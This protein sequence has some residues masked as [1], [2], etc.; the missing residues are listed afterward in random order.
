MNGADERAR[1]G[2]LALGTSFLVLLTKTL[3]FVLTGSAAIY[4]DAM[5][6]IVNVAAAGALVWGLRVAARPAD[7][8]HPY[9]HGKVEFFTAGL[10][11]ALIIV[12][13]ALI[14][15]QAIRNLV[16]GEFPQEL[17]AGVSLL[18]GA[19]VVNAL[20]GFHLIRQGHQHNSIALE[21]D[22]RHLLTDVVTSVGV[23]A[24]LLLVRF[25]GW[26]PLDAITALA[27]G[28]WILI[29]GVRLTRRS[30]ERLMD[31]A[32]DE[33]LGSIVDALA[34][35][36]DRG[37]IDIHGLRAWQAGSL[38]HTDLHVVVPRY[39]DAVAL[40]SLHDAVSDEISVVGAGDVIA[41][42]DPCGP[43]HCT[44]CTI[45]DCPVRDFAFEAAPELTVARATRVEPDDAD[46]ITSK[47]VVSVD[48]STEGTAFEGWW[49]EHEA[50]DAGISRIESALTASDLVEATAA[51]N[52]WQE[53]LES[54]FALEEQVYFP[55][56]AAISDGHSSIAEAA[57]MAH[58][59]LREQFSPVI[60]ALAAQDLVRSRD[61]FE[62]L[63]TDFREHETIEERMVRD[64][65]DRSP[66]LISD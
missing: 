39:W 48:H 55:I 42:F 30:I 19:T 13:S 56:V 24:G 26:A 66:G 16:S 34:R 58:G 61:T 5:E 32:D 25:T 41:H 63:L 28:A 65:P 20:L 51:V 22:G 64:L 62:R 27:V 1:S 18:V 38:L 40:H 35:I 29:E 54:H 8:D 43:D 49:E 31:A 3:A 7:Q 45:N 12:A 6:S 46:R 52:D 21:A 36:R 53:L 44:R 10:E 11:G 2:W 57:R 9:G 60:D 33:L 50:L 59:R 47:G 4:S 17:D 14:S 15:I 23:I 37:W